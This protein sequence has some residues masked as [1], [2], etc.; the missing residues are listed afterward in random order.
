M[1][2]ILVTDM[3]WNHYCINMINFDSVISCPFPAGLAN[4]H[5]PLISEVAVG[6]V[7][8]LRLV[9]VLSYDAFITVALCFICSA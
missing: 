4:I 9:F 2:Q 8:A 6:G 7:P 5:E 1:F 3:E